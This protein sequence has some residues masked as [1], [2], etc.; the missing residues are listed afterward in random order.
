MN[1]KLEHTRWPRLYDAADAFTTRLGHPLASKRT[2]AVDKLM[3]EGGGDHVA[4]VVQT[5]NR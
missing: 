2:G 4:A 3:A 1:S 5:A